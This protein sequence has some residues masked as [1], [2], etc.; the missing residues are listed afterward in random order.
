MKIKFLTTAIIFFLASFSCLSYAAETT[1][2]SDED[3]KKIEQQAKQG[4]AGAQYEL[5]L[6]YA[7]GEGVPQ[8]YI[9]AIVWFQ[10]AAE[11]G[12]STAQNLLGFTYLRGHG[13]SHDYTK[14]IK[15][16]QKAAKQNINEA[17]FNLGNMYDK[18]LGVPQDF[19]EAYF[20]FNLAAVKG[21]KQ[22]VKARDLFA[23]KLTPQALLK[24][25]KRA[26]EWRPVNNNQHQ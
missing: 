21:D 11:Q 6:M 10:K 20:W 5:G 8:D 2:N 12:N 19:E 9:K 17:Q 15:W 4:D 7:K 1:K 13:V 25:Q 18:G 24:V 16:F 3:I 22:F 14:A 26:E 23:K